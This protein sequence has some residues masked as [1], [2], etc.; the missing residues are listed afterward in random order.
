[1]ISDNRIKKLLS[2][3]ITMG[4]SNSFT[5]INKNGGNTV[6]PQGNEL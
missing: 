1:M 6:R 5:K 2:N 4:L 3:T